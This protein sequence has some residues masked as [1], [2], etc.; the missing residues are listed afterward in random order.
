MGLLVV[1]LRTSSLL[2]LLMKRIH[3]IGMLNDA[4]IIRRGKSSPA[5]KC[6][7]RLMNAVNRRMLLG[8]T[9]LLFEQRQNQFWVRDAAIARGRPNCV[10]A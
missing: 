1:S 2:N 7:H 4:V 5:L 10:T 6:P 3:K 8:V 9:H